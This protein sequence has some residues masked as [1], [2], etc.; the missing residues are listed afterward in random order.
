MNP[1]AIPSPAIKPQLLPGL[2]PSLPLPT[3]GPA[4]SQAIRWAD[5]GSS[6]G[7]CTSMRAT[8]LL[9]GHCIPRDADPAE[10]QALL[11]AAARRCFSNCPPQLLPLHSH[12]TFFCRH[13]HSFLFQTYPSATCQ[14]ASPPTCQQDGQGN[15]RFSLTRCTTCLVARPFQLLL[16]RMEQR[17]TPDAGTAGEQLTGRVQLP[18]G[19]SAWAF[20][21]P[22][23]LVHAGWVHMDGSSLMMPRCWAEPGED[24][25][26]GTA[27]CHQE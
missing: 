19:L 20:A 14:S 24:S 17:V 6:D 3:Q 21:S 10:A 13:L 11:R 27:P 18:K 2:P 12:G 4:E 8:E 1:G 9:C 7:S 16:R 15:W 22:Q 23:P 25:H 5:R 26:M